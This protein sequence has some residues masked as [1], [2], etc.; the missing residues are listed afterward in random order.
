MTC[1][2]LAR[3]NIRWSKKKGF[4]KIIAQWSS[5]CSRLAQAHVN[6]S[7]EACATLTPLFETGRIKMPCYLAYTKF[8]QNPAIKNHLLS[9]GNKRLAKTSPLDPVW[10]L[11]SRRMIPG[12][13]THASGQ[14]NIFSVRH[15]LLFAKQVTKVRPARPTCPL[16][17]GS[18]LAPE[19]QESTKFRKRRGRDR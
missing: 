11:V 19:T 16:L 3:S 13:T 9:T 1:H 15:F 6:A 17:V 14:E 2:T 5:S 12:P 18:A 8:T 4:I 10:A 7:V